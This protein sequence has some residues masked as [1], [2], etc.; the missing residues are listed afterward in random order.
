MNDQE[1]KAWMDEKR[2][3]KI[4]KVMEKK[5]FAPQYATSGEE[6]KDKVMALIP[7]GASVILTGSQTLEQIGVKPALRAGNAYQLIDPYEPGIEQAEGLARRKQGLTADVMVSST[8]ALTEDGVLVNVDGM[9]NRVAG[10]IFGP[11][12]VILAVGM[13][14]VVRD[15][16]QAHERLRSTARPMNNKRYGFPNPCVET[17][18]CHNCSNPTRIC[19][20]FTTIERS[21]IPNRIHVVLISESLGY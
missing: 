13:N 16:H 2:A 6:A 12:K 19:N 4:M 11:D 1:I 18:F 14:K 15:V 10:M 3:E 8:N 5:G 17:G 21:F 9:G 20:Y 7:E